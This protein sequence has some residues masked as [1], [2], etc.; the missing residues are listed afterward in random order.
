VSLCAISAE[1][2]VA[3]A[4]CGSVIDRF[5]LGTRRVIEPIDAGFPVQCIAFDDEV[6]LVIVGEPQCVAL[7][8]VS[9]APFVTAASDTAVLSVAVCGLAETV[10]NRFFATGHGNGAV[11]F[12]TVDYEAMALK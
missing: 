10:A 4:V 11:K 2:F 1:H 3:V 9:G 5:D 7:W 8:T 12:W 6:V